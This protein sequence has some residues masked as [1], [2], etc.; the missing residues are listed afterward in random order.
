MEEAI[1]TE[2]LFCYREVGK[3]AGSRKNGVMLAGV[4]PVVER[5]ARDRRRNGEFGFRSVGGVGFCV[6]VRPYG[7]STLQRRRT[8]GGS[9]MNEH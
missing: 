7:P 4:R 5:S 2:R 1:L 3:A 8:A 6:R 9:E